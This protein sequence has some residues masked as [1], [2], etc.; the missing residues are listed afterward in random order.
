MGAQ[1][2]AFEQ[3]KMEYVVVGQALAHM[4]G[5]PY[6]C[7]NGRDNVLTIPKGNG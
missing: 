5:S 4:N 2:N 3:R 1:R 7:Y 6:T